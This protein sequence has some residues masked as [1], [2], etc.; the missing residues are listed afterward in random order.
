M[1]HTGNSLDKKHQTHA[2]SR[3]LH[4]V[5]ALSI[6]DGCI[7]PPKGGGKRGVSSEAFTAMRFLFDTEQSGVDGYALWLDFNVENFRRKLLEIMSDTSPLVVAGFDPERRRSFRFNYAAW[8][9]LKSLG[10]E[11][12]EEDNV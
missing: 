12:A 2:N 8:K 10:M 5:I 4:A 7:A 6:N 3:L 9:N 1:R 11:V